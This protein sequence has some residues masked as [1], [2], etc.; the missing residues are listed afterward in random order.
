MRSLDDPEMQHLV[1]YIRKNGATARLVRR[2]VEAPGSHL[3]DCF[4]PNDSG[5]RFVYFEP[6]EVRLSL[7]KAELMGPLDAQ[8]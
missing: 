4:T 7:A 6:A 5:G 1:W 3:F 2:L 8:P